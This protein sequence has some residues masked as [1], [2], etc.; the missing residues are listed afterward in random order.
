MPPLGLNHLLQATPKAGRAPGTLEQPVAGEA[1]GFSRID[2]FDFTSGARTSE[3]LDIDNGSLPELP[4]ESEHTVWL[5]CQGDIA[6]DTLEHLGQT[7]GLHKLALEDVHSRGQRPKLDHYDDYVFIT[8]ALPRHNTG[9]Q[10]LFEQISVFFGA[11]FVLSFHHSANDVLEPLRRRLRRGRTTNDTPGSDYLA[12]VIAD[13]VVDWGFDLLND[14]NDR[15]ESLENEIFESLRND[16]ITVIHDLR[17]SLIAMRKIFRN[18]H[19]MLLRWAGLDH[20]TLADAT[21]P[22]IRDAQD[23]A[24]RVLD[25]ADGY[26]ETSG[27]LLD[28][29][30]SLNSNRLNETT[31]LLTLVATIFL[32]LSFIASVY[33]MNFDTKSPWNMPELGWYFGYFWALGVMALTVIGMLVFYRRRRWL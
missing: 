20:P 23:H 32:P 29:W 5:H 24:R 21:R 26:Y 10:L 25:I 15:L 22:F 8:L 12:Y 3:Q 1:I 17:Q 6:A 30:L 18:Q 11:G 4:T 27:T 16:V 33:G 31:R 13:V 14:F 7:F 2:R 19:E 28:T 9:G